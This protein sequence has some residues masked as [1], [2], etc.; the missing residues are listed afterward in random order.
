MTNVL[1]VY[2][3][4]DT[5]VC[6]LAGTCIIVLVCLYVQYSGTACTGA[7]S[8]PETGICI[9]LLSLRLFLPSPG[10]GGFVRRAAAPRCDWT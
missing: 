6:D 2:I 5:I 3:Q 4:Y 10:A 9:M 1:H 8:L 7:A